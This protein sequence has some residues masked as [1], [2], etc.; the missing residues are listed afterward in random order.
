LPREPTR[1]WFSTEPDGTSTG[2]LNVPDNITPIACRPGRKHLLRKLPHHPRIAW[3]KLVAQ[4]ETI[5]SIGM[6]DWLTSV[7]RHDPWYYS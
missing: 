3:R 7:S 2:K 1:S 6:R 4:P 5:T